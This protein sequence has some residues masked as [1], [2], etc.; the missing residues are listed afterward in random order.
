MI[1]ATQSPHLQRQQM[2]LNL[3]II[4]LPLILLSTYCLL[5][6][7]LK[8]RCSNSRTRKFTRLVVTML[9]LQW[10][11]LSVPQKTHFREVQ[12]PWMKCMM[13]LLPNV[14]IPLLGWPI[15][16]PAETSLI[17]VVEIFPSYLQCQLNTIVSLL[18]VRLFHRFPQVPM[19]LQ[20]MVAIR[21]LASLYL[22]RLALKAS[23]ALKGVKV[24]LTR[25]NSK[26]V[27]VYLLVEILISPGTPI[28]S[29]KLTLLA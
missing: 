15:S 11:T 25:T 6:S 14:T 17:S 9:Q 5:L 26:R 8:G 24:I 23:V 21:L 2:D 3:A 27:L 10:R 28:P 4:S 20:H 22:P 7:L 29:A 1:L 12:H 18:V 13:T 16:M 19:H